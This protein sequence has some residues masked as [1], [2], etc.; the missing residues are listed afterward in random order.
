MSKQVY[1]IICKTNEGKT[2]RYHTID[3]L[4]WQVSRLKKLGC[5]DI[6]C[7]PTDYKN[8]MVLEYIHPNQGLK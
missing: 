6:S 1:R 4:D 2:L 8:G 5:Y 3:R 7:W